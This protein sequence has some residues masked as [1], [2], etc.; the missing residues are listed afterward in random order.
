CDGLGGTVRKAD[1]GLHRGR[2]TAMGDLSQARAACELSAA[3]LM[4]APGFIDIHGHS[5]PGVLAGPRCESK[6]HQGVTTEL[7][8]MCGYSP[9]PVSEP[10]REDLRA[11]AFFPEAEFE[12]D[13]LSMAEYLDRVQAARPS[14]NIVQAVGHT[15]LR[16]SVMGYEAR[17]ATPE[18][19]DT[20]GR[21]L[22]QALEEGGAG[23]SSGLIYPPGSFAPPEELEFLCRV[24]ARFGRG[25]Y[26]HMRS[27]GDGLIDSV[28]ET[29]AA[30]RV[31]GV[32]VEIA[33]HKAAGR[34][35]WGK[36]HDSMALIERARDE[37]VDVRVDVYPYTAGSTTMTSLLPDWAHEGG[38]EALLGRLRDPATRRRLA[39][40]IQGPRGFAG[41]PWG[42]EAWTRV[43]VAAVADQ[44]DRE[45]EGL[46][47][48]QL[49]QVCAKPPVE[50]MFDLLL[51]HETRVSI[52]SF[53]MCDDDMAFVLGHTLSTVGSDASAVSALNG[54]RHGKPHPRAYGTFPRVLGRFAR[55]R[56]LMPLPEA[57]R[58][59]TS[60]PARRIG[61]RDRGVLR[62]G[63]AA[64]VVVFDPATIMDRATYAD[65]HQFPAGIRQ[66]WVNGVLVVHEGHHTGAGPGQVLRL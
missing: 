52:V 39:D 41:P 46:T 9:A 43:L 7:C 22:A 63:A 54:Q 10:C 60:E 32:P 56:K 59:M 49:G 29:I 27:E 31:A 4:V 66:V 47:L 58:K 11:G 26:T 1:V 53:T 50:A 35:N 51:A 16:A 12:W 13:W 24:A 48:A 28:C 65:P 14:M 64:D 2:I 5:D 25:Y 18:E 21:M 17:P 36:V 34:D 20:M 8:G 37:G 44:R 6:V 3:G 55:D 62:E 23:F 57:I 33:H 30:A 42:E 40:E 38:R 15:P 61:L 45:F 19:L